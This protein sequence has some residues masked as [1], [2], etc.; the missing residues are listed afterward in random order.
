MQVSFDTCLVWTRY[1]GFEKAVQPLKSQMQKQ[2]H[3]IDSQ[4]EKIEKQNEE[5]DKRA[6]Q[7]ALQLRAIEILKNKEPELREVTKEVAIEKIVY[8]EVLDIYI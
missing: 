1:A 5:L 7:I 6:K 8:H 2:S 4:N 3:V